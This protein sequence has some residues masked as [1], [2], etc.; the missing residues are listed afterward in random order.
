MLRMTDVWHTAYVLFIRTVDHSIPVIGPCET[1]MHY[2]SMLGH[3]FT[4]LTVLE[5]TKPLIENLSKILG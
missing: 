4:V 3:K 5:R 1:A 2:A